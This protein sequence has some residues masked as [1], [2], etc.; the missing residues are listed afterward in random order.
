MSIDISANLDKLKGFLQVFQQIHQEMSKTGQSTDKLDMAISKTQSIA[1]NLE[2]FGKKGFETS[3]R[4]LETMVNL[5][6]QVDSIIRNIPEIKPMGSFLTGTGIGDVKRNV[7]NVVLQEQKRRAEENLKLGQ[8][9]S[10]A[11]SEYKSNKQRKKEI[12]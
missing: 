6:S 1:K 4:Q 9:T 3:I 2:L 11:L 10:P 5:A 7:E 8:I 12:S